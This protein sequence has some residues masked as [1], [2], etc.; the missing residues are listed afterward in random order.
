MTIGNSC[1]LILGYI[2]G[3]S[4]ELKL[5]V[6][7]SD[8]QKNMVNVYSVTWFSIKWKLCQVE[9]GEYSCAPSKSNKL[10]VTFLGENIMWLYFFSFVVVKEAI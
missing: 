6:D 1:K 8:K 3:Y 4:A 5:W 7:N 9:F 10:K 2:C